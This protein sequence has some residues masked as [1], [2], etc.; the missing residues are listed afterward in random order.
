M[1]VRKTFTV[2]LCCIRL[3]LCF[4]SLISIATRSYDVKKFFDTYLKIR[5]FYISGGDILQVRRVN[6]V[7]QVLQDGMLLADEKRLL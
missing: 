3:L 4:N 1:P 2:V 5:L 7:R 6:V